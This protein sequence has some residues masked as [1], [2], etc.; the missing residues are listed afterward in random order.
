MSIKDQLLKH[1][2]LL[3]SNYFRKLYESDETSDLIKIFETEFKDTYAQNIKDYDDSLAFFHILNPSFILALEKTLI[4][5][6]LSLEDLKN[7]VMNIYEQ[8]MSEYYDTQVQ[9][10]ENSNN[11]WKDIIQ[12]IKKGNKT[13]Y[14]NEYFDLVEIIEMDNEYGFN[15]QKCIY[16]EIFQ[17]NNR[18][19]LGSILCEFDS[20]FVKK[21][22]KWVEFGR[23][24]TIANGGKVCNF[25]FKEKKQG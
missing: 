21:F 2:V 9:S 12:L 20:I 15:I 5:K 1:F 8:M 4:K 22:S 3:T 23:E 19:D 7:H 13:T 6:S 17:K 24:N 14:D 25:R 10:L 18:S 11:Q 16:F